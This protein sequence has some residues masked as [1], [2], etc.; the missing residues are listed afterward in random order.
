MTTKL[1]VAI[2]ENEG[3]FKHWTLLVTGSTHETIILN[4]MGSSTRYRFEMRGPDE[5]ESRDIIEM[6]HLCDVD[7]SATGAII[8]AAENLEIHN[9]FPGYNYQDYVLDLLDDLEN[10]GIIDGDAE[11]A[12][13][14]EIVRGKQEGLD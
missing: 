6:I 9:E 11:Y 13:K 5:R 12:R 4:I 3:V 8:D 10:R 1:H 7:A 14:K 2:Y